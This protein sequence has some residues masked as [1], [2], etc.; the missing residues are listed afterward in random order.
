MVAC[1][2]LEVLHNCA[3]P[4]K[5]DIAVQ[6][7]WQIFQATAKVYYFVEIKPHVL[8]LTLF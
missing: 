7:F 3:A 5:A 2:F 4:S 1:A 8:L 6:L